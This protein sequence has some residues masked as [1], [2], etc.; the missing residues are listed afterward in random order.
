MDIIM[1]HRADLE[2][3]IRDAA[4]RGAELA[5]RKA[6]KNRPSQYNKTDAARELDVSR[7]TLYAMIKNGDVKLNKVGKVSA[8]E[9]DRLIS[10]RSC[11]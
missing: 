6:P 5:L 9:I 10:A 4:I 8:E 11:A 7:P 2:T 3:A 1:I